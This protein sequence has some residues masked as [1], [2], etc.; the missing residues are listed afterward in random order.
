MTTENALPAIIGG[1]CLIFFAGLSYA[2]GTV[3]AVGEFDAAIDAAVASLR[4][5]SFLAVFVWVTTLGAG[6]TLFAV[7]ATAT[8]LLWTGPR[9]RFIGPFWMVYLGTEA[10]T[11][12]TKFALDRARPIFLEIAHA[13]SPS[14]PSAHAAGA[15][16]VYGFLAYIVIRSLP[17]SGP[18]R[19]VVLAVA[20]LVAAAVALSRV[21]LGVHFFSD[22]AGGLTVAGAWL[23][24]GVIAVNRARP[25]RQ[26][27]AAER[28]DA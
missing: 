9:R 3:P 23:C 28:R 18:A 7:A 2:I 25:A 16:A 22:V 20:G 1:V 8:V 27:V 15:A 17:A 14:F 10:M 19:L 6:A 11:W 12:G 21:V 5:A 26:D 13:S 24:V 4:T